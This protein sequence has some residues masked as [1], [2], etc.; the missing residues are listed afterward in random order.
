VDVVPRPDAAPDGHRAQ[1]AHR[2]PPVVP[3]ADHASD[4]V[5]APLPAGGARPGA[6]PLPEIRAGVAPRSRSTCNGPPAHGARGTTTPA[7]RSYNG[8]AS[9]GDFIII[10][11][12]GT[13]SRRS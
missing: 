3:V 6:F 12:D 2:N 7:K 5:R 9:V 1:A 11:I 10:A 13:S 8:T 4:R